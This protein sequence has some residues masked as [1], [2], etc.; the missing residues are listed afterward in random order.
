MV[1]IISKSASIW[2]E[3]RTNSKRLATVYNGDEVEIIPGEYGGVYENNGFYRVSHKGQT[4]WINQSY[5]VFS[6]FEIILMEG[7]VPAYC[8]PDTYAKK[9]GSLNKLTRY[10]VLGTYGDFYIVNLRQA[11]AFIPMSIRHYDTTFESR[12]LPA[13]G[14]RNGVVL[15]KTTLRTGPGDW[16]ASVEEVKAGYEFTCVGEIDGWYMLAYSSKNTDGTVLVYV[17]SYDVQVNGYYS[18]ANG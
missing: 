16:Y 1:R 8:A 12:F 18:D 11:A 3:P 4:G 10:T 13:Y 15:S 9:V 17:R 2:K 14:D 5:C 7:N 6:P